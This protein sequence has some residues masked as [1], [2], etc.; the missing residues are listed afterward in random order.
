MA[1]QRKVFRIEEMMGPACASDTPRI[2][3]DAESMLRH[4]ELMTEIRTLREAIAR[5]NPAVQPAPAQPP[6]LCDMRKLKIELDVIGE[7]IKQTK[8]EIVNLQ[9]HGFDN[10]RIARVSGELAAVVTGTEQATGR[11][12]ESAEEIEEIARALSALVRDQFEADLVQDL[13]DRVTQIYEA[14]N[15]QNLTG[16]RIGKVASTLAMV[17]DHLARMAEIW[18]IIERFN[19]KTINAAPHG[20]DALLNGPKLDGDAGHTS[21]NEIDKLF[22]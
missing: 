7:A 20:L 4:A 13:Q 18:D 16:Q 6:A 10:S 12:L 21:Q 5:Q 11:I 9:D 22:H 2:A 17:E 14:C 19:N 15:F 3:H 8:E 1:D